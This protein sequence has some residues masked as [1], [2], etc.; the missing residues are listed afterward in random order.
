[1][2]IGVNGYYL[3][4]LYSGIGQYTLNLL[5]AL[6]E[7][8]AKNKY[9]IFSPT[10]IEWNF[11]KNFQ[12]KVIKP[13]P[14]FPKTFLNRFLWEEF[15]LGKAIKTYRIEVFHSPYQSLP[16]GAEKIANVVTIHDAIPWLFPFERKQV[17]YRWYCD[18]R[19]NLLR[20]RAKKIITISDTAKLDIAPVY[21]LKPETIEITYESVDPIF[22]E[23][24]TKKEISEFKQKYSI[25]KDFILYVGGLK[26]HKNLRIL[27][28]A[29]DILVKKNGFEG[30]LYIVG[31]IRE[32]TPVSSEIYYK[33]KDLKTYAK[34]KR[35]KNRVNFPGFV[36][37][38]DLLLFLH[39]AKCFVS[40]SL[41]EGFGLPALEALTVGT[42]CVLSNLGAFPE[43]A[44]NAALLVYPY[45]PHRIAEALYQVLTDK[46]LRKEL[47]KKGKERA[48]LFDRI[49]MA[50]RVL[51]IYEEVWD[52]YKIK[53][54]P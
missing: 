52:D 11:P 9:Y 19:K 50:K 25:N 47:I 5:G 23:R 40:I 49:K 27:I 21:G 54:K 7:V 17:S 36:P 16:R 12:L 18:L 20:Q 15:Q 8:D 24:P 13:W 2:R 44:D 4:T 48:K 1:M 31:E 22:W 37:R 38:K 42:P 46:H 53:F 51:D 43:I 3:T 10:E 26:R 30:D 41:Y 32:T 33:V 39:L 28:K 34:L 6:A 35:I 45:G 14:F 29:F